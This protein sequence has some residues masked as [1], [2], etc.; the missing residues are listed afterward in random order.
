MKINAKVLSSSEI[1]YKTKSGEP[2]LMYKHE[3]FLPDYPAI[4]PVMGNHPTKPGDYSLDVV[5]TRDRQSL[6]VQLP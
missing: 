5:L 2:G 3:V 1:K 4:I 6:T